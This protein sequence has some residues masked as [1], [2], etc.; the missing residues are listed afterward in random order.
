MLRILHQWMRGGNHTTPEKPPPVLERSAADFLTPP[1]GG[2]RVTWLGH[3]SLFVEIDKLRILIDP[4]WSERVSPLPLIGPRRF[5]PPPLPLTELKKLEI[6]AIV[7]SHDHY[8][9]LDRG[10]IMEIGES[11]PRFIVPLG[12]GAHL[13]EWGIDRARITELDWWEETRLDDL[14]FTATPARHF[15]GRTIDRGRWDRTLWSGWAIRN[16]R[17]RI[18][19][20]G[21][22]AMFNGIDEIGRRLGPFDLTMIEIGA[23]NEMWPDVHIGPEQ[24]V[25]AHKRLRGRHLLPVH[26]GTFDLALHSWTEPIERA[27]EAAR[28]EG[29]VLFT[30]RPGGSIDASLLEKTGPERVN[31]RWWPALPWQSAEEAPIVSTGLNSTEPTSPDFRLD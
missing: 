25:L 12:V 28:K 3:S 27:L 21:D 5:H 22:T 16:S 19:Y 31:R 4:V 29:V 6:D 2:L 18:Y 24:A 11:V 8:D 20:S 13:E 15:S 10:T 14:T 7:I 30:P 23:Y 9:H 17:H 1:T 26:W